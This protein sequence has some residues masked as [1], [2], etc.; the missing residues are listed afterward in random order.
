MHQQQQQL[1]AEILNIQLHIADSEKKQKELHNK[2]TEYDLRHSEQIKNLTAQIEHNCN[3]IRHSHD[4]QTEIHWKDYDELCEFINQNFFQ[5]ANKLKATGIL[6]EKEI[7]LCILVFVNCIEVQ[8]MSTILNYAPTAIRN[9]KQ[10]VAK[11]FGIR[12][13]DL[14]DFLIKMALSDY[15]ND[16][17]T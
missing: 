16:N 15:T 1:Q 8:Q 12:S 11:K 3:A 13:K 14:R 17:L 4:W 5:L 6:N 10:N 9:Y 7:R 2:I